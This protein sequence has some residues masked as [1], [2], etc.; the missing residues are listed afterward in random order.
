MA[1]SWGMTVPFKFYTENETAERSDD[2]HGPPDADQT[3][4]SHSRQNGVRT[5][6]LDQLIEQVDQYA[7][8]IGDDTKIASQWEQH[9]ARLR[10]LIHET[11][12][13]DEAGQHLSQANVLLNDEVSTLK[14]A[15]N[16]EQQAHLSQKNRFNAQSD[17]LRETRA[18]LQ[19]AH[20]DVA[21]LTRQVEFLSGQV[22]SLKTE[23]DEQA[24]QLESQLSDNQTLRAE[25]ARLNA[26]LQT[27]TASVTA[28]RAECDEAIGRTAD[29][30]SL[31]KAD[32]EYR[33]T[34][35]QD[36]ATSEARV[37]VL[38]AELADLASQLDLARASLAEYRAI[39]AD[40][41][42]LKEK[43]IVVLEAKIEAM[44]RNAI[45]FRDERKSM[46]E[47]V[48]IAKRQLEAER[49]DH[50]KSAAQLSATD[51][52]LASAKADALS[53][54]TKLTQRD[55]KIADL[56]ATKKADAKALKDLKADHRAAVGENKSLTK[57]VKRLEAQ[58][59]KQKAM[60][61]MGAKETSRK[62]KQP[63]KSASRS[64]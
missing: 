44:E 62:A 61:A 55:H 4:K 2:A 23:M 49:V 32:I 12:S 43:T 22:S 14:K 36:L 64:K 25:Q 42:A 24:I 45:S 57:Q 41:L 30:K 19:R 11:Q 7:K 28:L 56:Q 35:Q 60:L 34:M 50:M 29:L 15:L 8:D 16:H 54:L 63:A 52:E 46:S 58:L 17:R 20:L 13:G 39:S 31:L 48:A 10:T 40:D 5:E 47:A 59:A 38:E 3:S 26:K 27:E 21:N 51:G 6:M 37:G 18:G 1:V 9:L 33:E 53:G